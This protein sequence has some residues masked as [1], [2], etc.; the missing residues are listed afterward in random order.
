[1]GRPGGTHRQTHGSSRHRLSVL[2]H[3]V[4][5]QGFAV[6]QPITTQEEEVCGGVLG[7][8]VKVEVNHDSQ[9]SRLALLIEV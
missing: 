8:H 5:L 7:G 4:A 6:K 1:M 3:L 9:L 2:T